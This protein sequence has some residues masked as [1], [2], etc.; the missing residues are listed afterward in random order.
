M[1]YTKYRKIKK[2]EITGTWGDFD[3]WEDFGETWGDWEYEWQ[4]YMFAW[5]KVSQPIKNAL[6]QVDWIGYEGLKRYLAELLPE[7]FYRRWGWFKWDEIFKE[8]IFAVVFGSFVE[9]IIVKQTT[10]ATYLRIKELFDVVFPAVQ[11][12]VFVTMNDVFVGLVFNGIGCQVEGQF[13]FACQ[14]IDSY[15]WGDFETWG[16][17][18]N[19]QWGPLWLTT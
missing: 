14:V 2:A 17:F 4:S 15:R 5:L 11:V 8:K 18:P 16:D 3:I 19:D 9:P 7:S 12:N 6:K 10:L 1:L 13:D